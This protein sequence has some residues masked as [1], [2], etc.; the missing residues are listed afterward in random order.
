MYRT[1]TVIISVFFAYLSAREQSNK[2]TE[3][4]LNAKLILSKKNATV[5]QSNLIPILIDP[6]DISSTADSDIDF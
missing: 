5:L 4:R 1:Y 6:N 2:A 3:T